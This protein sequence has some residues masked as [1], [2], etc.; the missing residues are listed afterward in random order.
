MKCTNCNHKLKKNTKFCPF[1][2]TGQLVLVAV[3]AQM[4]K[5]CSNCGTENPYDADFC[6]GCG[7]QLKVVAGK[8]KKKT[9]KKIMWGIGIITV[10]IFICV[11]II[12]C[13]NKS[14]EYLF[15]LKDE[16]VNVIDIEKYEDGSVEYGHYNINETIYDLSPQ[17][18]KDGKYICVP[19]RCN[20]VDGSCRLNLMR[21]DKKKE[22]VEIADGVI[23]FLLLDDN[24]VLYKNVEGIVYISDDKGNKNKIA[25]HV[26]SYYVDEK[27][28]NIVIVCEMAAPEEFYENSYDIYHMKLDMKE[29]KNQLIRDADDV[30]VS[31]DLTE[32]AF[33]KDYKLYHCSNFSER[34][35]ISEGV[36][37]IIDILEKTKEI[38]YTSYLG[39]ATDVTFWDLVENEGYYYTYSD[40]TNEDIEWQLMEYE[41][42]IDYP[43]S[44]NCYGNGENKHDCKKNRT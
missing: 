37:L 1:C 31:K 36:G 20:S 41:E 5:Y 22:I 6:V 12:L 39:P 29:Q 24:R 13:S 33:I 21:L 11:G 30:A 26:E 44:L 27:Q 14:K 8:K 9:F 34:E 2:G 40:Y 32:I 43:I 3:S 19:V 18:S 25:A 35:L 28:E 7:A 17:I 38:F 23:E 10:A 16:E 42:L 4:A 15:Y